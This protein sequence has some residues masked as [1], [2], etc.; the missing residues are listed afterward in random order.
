MNASERHHPALGVGIVGLGAAA[1]NMISGFHRSPCFEIVAAA[2]IDGALLDRFKRDH[3]GAETSADVERLCSN[4]TVDL[5]YIAT[6]NRLHGEHARVALEHGKHV[7]IEKPM[8]VT[9][10]D[11]EEMIGTADRNGV[12][13]G[14][15]VKHSF[16]PRIQKIRE[17]ALTGELGRLSPRGRFRTPSPPIRIPV[18]RKSGIRVLSRA[19][20]HRWR[21][22]T[23]G[24]R[25]GPR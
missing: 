10:E 9:L 3:S 1:V 8:A 16:E 25:R 7:L 5:V 11:A 4:P 6:P 12:L 15:N 22:R 23:I 18:A 24:I 2:D 20:R 14:V 13:L 19:W 17:L 21:P